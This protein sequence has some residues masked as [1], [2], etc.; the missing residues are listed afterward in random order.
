MERLLRLLVE[1][2]GSDLY[3]SANAQPTIRL[4]GQCVPA[5]SRALGPQDPVELLAILIGEQN[6]RALHPPQTLQ[7]MVN[8]QDSGRLR[9]QVFFQRGALAFVARYF[10][11][12][13]PGI[14]H[15]QL[16]PSLHALA[17]APAGLLLIAGAAGAGKSTTAAALLEY[18]N[19]QLSG[20]ILALENSTEYLLPSKKSLVNQLQ[21]GVDIDAWDKAFALA[22]SCAADVV[23]LSEINDA[24][25][26]QVAL[27][28]AQSGV[29]SVATINA[30]STAQALIHFLQ[31]F[32]ED[33]R[34]SVQMQ[35]GSALQ[36]VV[37]QKLLRTKAG[38]RVAVCEILTPSERV[39]LLLER[40]E[41]SG[42]RA[43]DLSQQAGCH[44]LEQD[45]LRL[46]QSGVNFEDAALPTTPSAGA[47]SWGHTMFGDVGD[48]VRATVRDHTPPDSASTTITL[49]LKP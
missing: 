8:L 7:K 20:H 33:Q 34:H 10:P 27:R 44:S 42:L 9:V 6:A 28:L 47:V 18:R 35:L 26:A 3:I 29:L 11:A 48:S 19:T 13:L 1:K 14:G 40:S 43:L 12:A 49:S 25:S 5:S 36:A 23:Y 38:P 15:G 46:Q 2:N 45:R 24:S 16:S 37:F 21:V 32:P 39:A 31:Y 22:G 17:K 30:P 4:H 41:W